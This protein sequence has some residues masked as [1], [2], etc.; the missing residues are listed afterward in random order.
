MLPKKSMHVVFD[1]EGGRRA[2]TALNLNTDGAGLSVGPVQYPQSTGDLG[3]LLR[4]WKEADPTAFYYI[5]APA[6]EELLAVTNSQDRLAPVD[7]AYLWHAPWVGRFQAALA[8][9]PFVAAL[10]EMVSTG[11]H[12]QK[13][14]AVV[15]MLNVFSERGFALAFDRAVNT[16]PY[17]AVED[18]RRV[19]GAAKQTGGATYRGVLEAFAQASVDRYVRRDGPPAGDTRWRQ[20]GHEWHRFSGSIDKAEVVRRRVRFILDAP[21]LSDDTLTLVAA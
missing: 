11:L 9:P 7:E 5:F 8:H 21:D 17:G 10:E 18:A 3:T 15:S 19:L 16:G 20:V 2:W 6:S 13:A 4:A 14:S 12:A 1:L